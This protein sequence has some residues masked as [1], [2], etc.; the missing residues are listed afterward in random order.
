MVRA[1]PD[2]SKPQWSNDEQ[3]QRD[4]VDLVEQ[5]RHGKAWKCSEHDTGDGLAPCRGHSPS[6]LDSSDH[7]SSHDEQHAKQPERHT[8]L[9]LEAIGDGRGDEDQP[10]AGKDTNKDTNKRANETISHDPPP[11]L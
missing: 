9:V 6:T 5:P 8:G 3:D 10:E 2:Y 11:S 4:D 1:P 7:C